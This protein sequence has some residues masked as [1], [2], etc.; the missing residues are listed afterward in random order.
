MAMK[1][2]N[3]IFVCIM[4]F[5]ACLLPLS[6][7]VFAAD[8][9]VTL[10]CVDENVKIPDMKWNIYRVGERIDGQIVLTGDFK[11]YSVDLRDLSAENIRSSAAVLEG[12][13]MA[14]QYTPVVSGVTDE[15]GD[16]SFRGLEKGVYLASGK[17]VTYGNYSYRP[18]P[19]IIEVADSSEQTVLPKF[20]RTSVFNAS[21][22]SYE[23]KK[24]WI[25]NDDAYEMRPVDVTVDLYRDGEFVETVVLSEENEWEYRWVSSD[26]LASWN[27]VERKIP[28][29]YVVSIEFNSKQYLIKNSYNPDIAIDWDDDQITTSTTTTT[30]QTPDVGGDDDSDTTTTATTQTTNDKD[31]STDTQTTSTEIVS[32]NT[33]VSSSST[34]KSGSSGSTTSSS[35][36]TTVTTAVSGG[37]DNSGGGSLPQT[38]QLWWP[39]I[40][41]SLGGVIFIFMGIK[42][43]SKKENNETI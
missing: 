36:T 39:V 40:P 5:F 23:V 27:V 6:D 42:L 19:V 17:R 41:L 33:D 4:A 32:N 35:T 3:I 21:N 18:S 7:E 37:G 9:V 11:R 30:T 1:V 10:S 2:K 14:F 22:V 15:N 8:T 20:Y 43:K 31:N 25:D 24:V 12:Y 38:G 16:V 13:A 29:K 34:E 26:P 28:R